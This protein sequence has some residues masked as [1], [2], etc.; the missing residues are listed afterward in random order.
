[1]YEVTCVTYSVKY[2]CDYTYSTVQKYAPANI[3]IKIDNMWEKF[4]AFIGLD[5]NLNVWF[6]KVLHYLSA[7]PLIAFTSGRPSLV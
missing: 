4:I 2:L 7:E 3:I 6:D 1:M 5:K